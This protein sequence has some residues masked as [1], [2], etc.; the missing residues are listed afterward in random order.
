MKKLENV[1]KK[2]KVVFNA[3]GFALTFI[4][5]WLI[6]GWK[7]FVA[8]DTP[9]SAIYNV[10][11]GVGLGYLVYLGLTCDLSHGAHPVNG[12]IV[13]AVAPFADIAWLVAIILGGLLTAVLFLAEK[14][15]DKE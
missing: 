14:K 5:G 9:M 15:K 8:H 13:P 10:L 1:L 3:V 7:W 11:G 12:I 6:K 2:V 4:Y